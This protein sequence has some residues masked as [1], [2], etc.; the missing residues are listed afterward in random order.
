MS[1]NEEKVKFSIDNPQF[2]GD[3]YIGRYRSFV[4]ICNPLHAFYPNSRVLVMKELLDNQR[5]KE[6]EEF[7]KTGKKEVLLS[8]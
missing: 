7:K 4:K 5:K 8:L 2:D 1:K 3:T 6:A